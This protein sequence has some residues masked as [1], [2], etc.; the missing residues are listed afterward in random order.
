MKKLLVL[1]FLMIILGLVLTKK[2]EILKIYETYFLKEEK[3]VVTL[4][5]VNP[6]YRDYDFYF[7]QNTKD[8]Y[9]KEEKDLLNIF[10]T[11][12]NAGK[13]KFTFYCDSEYKSCIDDVKKL[14]NNQETLSNINNFVHPYN[15]FKHIETEYSEDG[16][17]TVSLEKTYKEEEITEI[18]QRI[19]ELI[20]TLITTSDTELDN[21]RRIHDYIIDHSVYDSNRSD[22]QIIEYKSEIAYGPLFEGH[23][24]CGGYTDLMELFLEKMHIKNYKV[25]SNH[26]VWNAVYLDNSWYHLDLTWDDPVT[27]N[28]T[29]LLEHDFFMIDTAK[30]LE[31]EKTEHN[32]DTNTYQEL[33]AF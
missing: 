20:P 19:E 23:G 31:I 4:G 33:K 25:A 6:Y 22:Q 27:S 12:I 5:E 16:K 14:A 29:N 21:I 13:D 1:A 2:E 3:E 7:V 8:F 28:H 32:F 10:Y 18:N 9:P 26:H 24:L 11:I 15:S 17:V 30:L